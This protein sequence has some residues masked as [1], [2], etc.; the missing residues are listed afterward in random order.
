MCVD[1]GYRGRKPT[2]GCKP[3]SA[4][5]ADPFSTYQPPLVSAHPHIVILVNVASLLGNVWEVFICFLSIAFV[6]QVHTGWVWKYENIKMKHRYSS[7]KDWSLWYI[8]YIHYTEHLFLLSYTW[9]TDIQKSLV[10][11]SNLCMDQNDRRVC[12]ADWDNGIGKRRHHT[13]ARTHQE[14]TNWGLSPYTY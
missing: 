6:N 12:C 10:P 1:V 9:I 2:S 13:W 3:Y 11:W 5:S 7:E 8:V 14:R 4:S